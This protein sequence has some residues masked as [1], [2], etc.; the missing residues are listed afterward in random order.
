ML[1]LLDPT[2]PHYEHITPDTV[3][4]VMSEQTQS[5]AQPQHFSTCPCGCT[6]NTHSATNEI[7]QTNI[8]QLNL[9]N[10]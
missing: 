8:K 10:A 1:P 6:V 7:K 4:V 5:L 2:V 9:I 3:N